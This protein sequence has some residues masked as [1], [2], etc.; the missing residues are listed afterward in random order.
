MYAQLA[1]AKRRYRVGV[2]AVGYEA[3]KRAPSDADRWAWECVYPRPFGAAV[4]ALE[5]QH[6][7][8]RGLLYALMRQESAFDPVVVSPASAVG[9]MQ[10][11]PSTAERAAREME[12][13]LELSEL[14]SPDVN[15]RLGGF[16]IA[17]LLRTFEG[18][19]PLAAAAYN[20]G[21]QAVSRWLHAGAEQDTDLWV[22]RIPYGETRHYVGRVLANLARYQWLEGGEAA[23]A[24]VPLQI[25]TGI[26]APADAY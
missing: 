25:P 23:V 15:L 10:L 11:M 3:L 9:L 16:Y 24:M 18:S 5:E 6:A 20:A 1:Q 14:T 21:P 2:N 13:G 17:K 4:R 8:P 26:K 22:A 12:M 19:L 7:V